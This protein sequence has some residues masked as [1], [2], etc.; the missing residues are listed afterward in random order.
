MF[1]EFLGDVNLFRSSL[2]RHWHVPGDPGFHSNVITCCAMCE[3][4]A[5]WLIAGAQNVQ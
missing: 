3:T 4:R 5:S 2:L 1:N